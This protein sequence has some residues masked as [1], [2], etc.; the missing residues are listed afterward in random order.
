[1]VVPQE[2]VFPLGFHPVAWLNARPTN[3]RMLCAAR[4]RKRDIIEAPANQIFFRITLN[5][6]Y[7]I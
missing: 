1:M 4:A 3:R 7:T 2:Y 6:K 5:V